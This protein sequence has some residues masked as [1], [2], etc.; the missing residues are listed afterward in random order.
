[1]TAQ[2]TVT[3]EQRGQ[4]EIF[5]LR[6]D[7]ATEAV[8]VPAWGN[9]CVRFQAQHP[10]L[11]AITFEAL[12]QR[13][14]SYGIP[15]LFPFPNRLR[16]GA[17]TFQG[18]RYV[19][20][21]PR[22]GFVRD[23]PWQVLETGAAAQEGAWIS[24]RC[25]AIQY[26]EQIL[27]QFPFPFR[28]DVTYRLHN[29]TL[30]METVAHNTGD[31]DMPMGFGIHPYFQRPQRGTLHVPARQY[32]E[33]VDSLPTGRLLD[34]TGMYDLR[35]PRDVTALTLDDIFTDLLADADGMVRC[36]L[37]D[38][39]H[40]MHTIVAFD[41]AQFPHVVVFTPPPPRQA[42]CIEPY[43]CPTDAFNLQQHGVESNL[44]RLQPGATRRFQISIG[45]RS[46]SR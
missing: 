45:I 32:W 11:E 28:L 5:A 30:S 41:A 10:V 21:P 16:D 19:L 12:A 7:D 13:P 17:F 4:V 38:H 31:C 40:G 20:D 25:E 9:N 15:I 36:T 2:Y 3:S 37:E 33:L 24:A 34:V 18:Q 26:A 14:T 35:Q 8:I 44:I 27:H 42:I 1:M 29:H 22:H 6:Q 46:M 23:K 43:T 39:H